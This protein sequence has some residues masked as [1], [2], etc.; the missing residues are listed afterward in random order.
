MPVVTRSQSV[1]PQSNNVVANNIVSDNKYEYTQFITTLMKMVSNE[2]NPN[3]LIQI[4]K[5]YKIYKYINNTIVKIYSKYCT[6]YPKLK[7]FLCIIYFKTIELEEDMIKY[8]NKVGFEYAIDK[9]SRQL[10]I[11]RQ[12]ISP[13]IEDVDFANDTIITHI[14][15]EKNNTINTRKSIK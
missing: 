10:Q 14:N 13:F 1:R 11:S 2:I 7:Q 5:L 8:Q 12:L 4:N 3:K 9:L 6:T 15:K